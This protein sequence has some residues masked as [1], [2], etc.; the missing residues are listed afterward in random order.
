M[1]D[2]ATVPAL[3]AYL[4]AHQPERIRPPGVLAQYDNYGVALAGYLVEVVA[5]E[6][7]ARYVQDHIL[8]PLK[9]TGTTF[10]QPHPAAIQVHMAAGYRPEGNDQVKET[11][12]STARGRRPGRAPWPPTGSGTAT[13]RT[14]L[15]RR[16]R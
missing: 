7:F 11:G 9:M 12:Q 14:R 2:P 13:S 1:R 16:K 3:G 15:P 4:A 6:P 10:A 8:A 5:G